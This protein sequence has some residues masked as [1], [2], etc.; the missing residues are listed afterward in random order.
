MSLDWRVVPI[1]R[2]PGEQTKERQ[3]HRF[4]TSYRASWGR[5]TRSGVDWSSTTDLLAREL[6]H[7]DAEN[8]LLQMAVTDRDI[9]ND[10]WIR[11]NARPEHPGVIL[12]FDS[13]FGPLS[14]PCDTYTDWQANVRAIAVSLE[15]LRGVDRHGVSKRGEQYRGWG[16]LPPAGGSTATMTT[17]AAARII[18]EAAGW[19]PDDGDDVQDV[20]D[21]P[22]DF[23]A[24]YRD[25]A[26]NTH[27]DRA[28]GSTERF[29]LIQEAKRVLE[30]HHGLGGRHG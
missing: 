13:K 14:Y 30:A 10:G 17:A 26:R 8:I 4:R 20:Q 2:W 29:Q 15:W 6:E 27:P 12:T 5:A 1:E 18:V 25:A 23:R 16:Q 28:G 22:D 3:A 7:L 11:A 19:D 24:Y 21:F 9:R